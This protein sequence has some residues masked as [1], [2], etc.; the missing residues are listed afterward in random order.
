[1]QLHAHAH[2]ID[3]HAVFGGMFSNIF[4]TRMFAVSNKSHGTMGNDLGL[5]T[6]HVPLGITVGT[7]HTIEQGRAEQG[8]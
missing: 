5:N 3:R 1:M 2:G 6:T 8:I 7:P 4:V